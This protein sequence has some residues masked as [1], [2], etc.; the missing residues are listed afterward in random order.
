MKVFFA[1]P[2]PLS[3][4]FSLRLTYHVYTFG[5]VMSLPT[6]AKSK[7]GKKGRHRGR[8]WREALRR[9]SK[10]KKKKNGPK[11][12]RAKKNERFFFLLLRLRFF[13]YEWIKFALSLILSLFFYRQNA[14]V[15]VR[16]FV[17]YIRQSFFFLL[18]FS[19][20]YVKEKN[21]VFS[22]IRY[23][24][25]SPCSFFTMRY[26]QRTSCCALSLCL[27]LLP[28]TVTNAM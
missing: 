7:E 13:F 16:S 3:V 20:L 6:S 4:S 8:Q 10:E 11:K 19:I 24:I 14:C 22:Y 23:I 5:A 21:S 25:Y 15:Q 27:S 17:L 12:F 2:P 26:H 18:S 9:I 1:R 28:W